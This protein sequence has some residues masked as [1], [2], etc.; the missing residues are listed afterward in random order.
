MTDVDA[1][2][3]D[4]PSGWKRESCQAMLVDIRALPVA[5]AES[6]KWGNPYFEQRG[7]VVK[8]YVAKE[9][10]NVYFY[11]GHLLDD[12][13]GVFE[14]TDNCRMRTIKITPAR[15]LDRAP[16]AELLQAAVALD[17]ADGCTGTPTP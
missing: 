5:L 11:K 1:F 12:P 13:Q 15:P 4:L 9:W 10:I 6:I 8:W 16:F 17:G 2:V 14:L 3:R 7:A